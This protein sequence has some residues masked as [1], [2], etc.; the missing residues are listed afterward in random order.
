MCDASG[1]KTC[2]HSLQNVTVLH[3]RKSGMITKPASA[4]LM[5][6]RGKRDGQGEVK[7]GGGEKDARRD[8]DGWE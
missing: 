7:G 4:N 1:R 5:G 3:W 6:V 2:A 8:C